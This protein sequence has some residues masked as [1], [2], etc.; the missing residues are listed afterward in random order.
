[1]NPQRALGRAKGRPLAVAAALALVAIQAWAG[2]PMRGAELFRAH[3]SGCHGPNGRPVLPAA[4][5]F[6]HPMAL[7]K[8]DL[9]LLA[10]VR[11]GRGAMPAYAGVLRDRDILDIISHLRTLK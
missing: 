3:C 5:D 6:T 8:P 2:D 1:M 7:L 11:S 9:A 10:T 4:P